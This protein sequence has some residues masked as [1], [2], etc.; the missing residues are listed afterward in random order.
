MG[1][2]LNL[3]VLT[4]ERVNIKYRNQTLSCSK[5]FKKAKFRHLL[6]SQITIKIRN[7]LDL[8]TKRENNLTEMVKGRFLS[9]SLA[10]VFLL[11]FFFWCFL[12]MKKK[13]KLSLP[14]F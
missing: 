3:A 6:P 11:V 2:A 4:I 7:T 14:D 5:I 10:Y 12:Y 1:L 13:L 8:H 9:I